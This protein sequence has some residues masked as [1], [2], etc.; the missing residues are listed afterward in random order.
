M[1]KNKII[2][3]LCLILMSV[4][5]M[6]ICGFTVYSFV[7]KHTISEKENRKLAQL[8]ELNLKNW[9]SGE[10]ANG[11]NLYLNDHV[12][13]RNEIISKASGF[14][15]MLKKNFRYRLLLQ[16]ITERTS[17]RMQLYFLIRLLHCTLIIKIVQKR[18]LSRVI[19]CLNRCLNISINI[20]CFRRQE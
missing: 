11:L 16:M 3:I 13:L 1:K 12:L 20:L 5:L 8:P 9:F 17:V 10:F 7:D 2:T 15:N 18:S 6:G 14:E 19:S 4:T